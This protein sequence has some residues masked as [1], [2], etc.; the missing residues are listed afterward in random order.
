MR[1]AEVDEDDAEERRERFGE[2]VWVD[3]KKLAHE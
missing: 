2:V 1:S 3:N